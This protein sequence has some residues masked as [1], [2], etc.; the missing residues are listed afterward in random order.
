MHINE[1]YEVSGE[2]SGRW[3]V[4][5]DHA[6]NSVPGWINGGSLGLQHDDMGRH[7]AF[8]PGIEALSKLL[9]N[10]LSGQTVLSR[11]S[12]LVID[13]NRGEDDPTLIMKLYDGSVIPA[14]R[15]LS[16]SQI[17]ERLDRL[18]HPYHHAIAQSISRVND[19]I[20][21]SLHS[22][23]P[24]LRSRPPRPWHVG[25]LSAQDR[26]LAD[27]MIAILSENSEICVGDNEPYTGALV[28]DAMD[29]HGVSTERPHVLIEIRNDLLITLDQQAHWA[30]YLA[31]VVYRAVA[32]AGL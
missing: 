4:T 14:N 18:Y 24:K 6:S 30:D 10:R 1:A 7:I 20:V 16:Q 22:F 8:D 32:I 12:R 23:T 2:Q 3:I 28:G 26:R 15:S 21:V 19:P 5:A 13:P 31:M 11:F 29:R 25:I 17:E 9:A 27:P